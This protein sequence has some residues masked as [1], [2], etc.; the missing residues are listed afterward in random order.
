MMYTFSEMLGDFETDL[1]IS[2]LNQ[3][4]E[5]VASGIPMRPS[6]LSLIQLLSE[7]STHHV[8]AI[9]Q[10]HI[11]KFIGGL[12]ANNYDME[13]SKNHMGEYDQYLIA[14]KVK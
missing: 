8:K 9:H 13:L 14:N 4:S 6:V 7:V 11:D 1:G 10:G 3:M 5:K 12:I 2:S